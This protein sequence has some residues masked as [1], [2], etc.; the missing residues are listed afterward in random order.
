MSLVSRIRAMNAADPDPSDA[1]MLAAM[2]GFLRTVGGEVQLGSIS[3]YY[4]EDYEQDLDYCG[5]NRIA[6]E[7][8]PSWVVHGKRKVP[9]STFRE[10]LMVALRELQVLL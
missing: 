7:K 1:D 10:A 4:D 2:A 6:V 5:P 9:Y 8:V 3:V